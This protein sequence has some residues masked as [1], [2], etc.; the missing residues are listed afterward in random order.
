MAPTPAASCLL[1][2]STT[3]LVFKLMSNKSIHV[4]QEAVVHIKLSVAYGEYI[5]TGH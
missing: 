4:E 1:S 3:G 2:F 5:P